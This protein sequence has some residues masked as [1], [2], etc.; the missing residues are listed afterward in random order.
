M[1]KFQSLHRS[2]WYYLIYKKGTTEVIPL[3][4][5][6]ILNYQSN[7]SKA[8]YFLASSP[9]PLASLS[10]FAFSPTF[11]SNE[12]PD[13]LCTL[14]NR[15]SRLNNRNRRQYE[16]PISSFLFLSATVPETW[17]RARRPSGHDGT[18]KRSGA[19]SWAILCDT[20]PTLPSDCR[21]C[22]CTGSLCSQVQSE[23]LQKYP[24]SCNPPGNSFYTLQQPVQ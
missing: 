2:E 14:G 3:L 8:C 20:C 12:D 16:D 24:L 23:P 9:L 6:I 4:Y 22:P 19:W 17:H 15:R 13:S 10:S 11:P 1:D 18:G 7:E 21:T 5:G